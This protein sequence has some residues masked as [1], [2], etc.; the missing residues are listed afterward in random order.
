MEKKINKV[1]L[2]EKYATV[3]GIIGTVIGLLLMIPK[4]YDLS[5]MLVYIGICLLVTG[6]FMHQLNDGVPFHGAGFACS[7][8]AAILFTKSRL[9]YF[10]IASLAI[11]DLYRYTS[12]ILYLIFMVCGVILFSKRLSHNK[13]ENTTK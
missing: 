12:F 2:I 3:T 5:A 13:E 6:G 10:D 4:V 1:I 9:I 8:V 7:G 11:V